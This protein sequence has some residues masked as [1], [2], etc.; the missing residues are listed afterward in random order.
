[1]AV[2]TPEWKREANIARK[3]HVKD[4]WA[5]LLPNVGQKWQKTYY[6]W[7]FHFS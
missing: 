4:I 2:Q 7:E 5:K 6:F 1:M 3:P